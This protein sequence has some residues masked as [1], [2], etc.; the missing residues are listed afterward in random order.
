MMIQMV[1]FLS[2]M[3]L[4]EPG[5]SFMVGCMIIGTNDIEETMEAAWVSPA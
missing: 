5:K 4:L 3:A 2:S 1:T